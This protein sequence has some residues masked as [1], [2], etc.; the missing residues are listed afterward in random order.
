MLLLSLQPI[1][2]SGIDLATELQVEN[3]NICKL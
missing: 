1:L 2:D 3:P